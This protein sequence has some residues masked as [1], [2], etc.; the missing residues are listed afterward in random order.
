MP[1]PTTTT[2]P[3]TKGYG[4]ASRGSM[5]T[6]RPSTDEGSW[7]ESILPGLAAAATVAGGA[8]LLK[9]NPGSIG[10]VAS[11][12]NQLRQQLMLS[13][14]AL[15]KSLLGNAGAAV[16]QSFERGTT[17][18][19]SELLSAQTVR[20]AAAAW[21]R[22]ATGGA[23]QGGQAP[24]GGNVFTKAASVFAPGRAMGAMDEATQK[25][26]QRAGLSAKEAEAAALQS[27][28]EPGVAEALDSP[29]ARYV[30]PFRRQPFNQFLEG[31]KTV[32]DVGTGRMPQHPKTLA[33]YSLAGGVHGMATEEDPIPASLPLAM[34]ASGKYAL[35]YAIA[36]L[37]GRNVVGGKGMGGIPGSV[38]PVSEYGFGSAFSRPT[39]PFT[40]PAAL[41]ALEKLLGP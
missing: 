6:A 3:P 4:S 7:A 36:A 26:L 5:G 18:P 31:W 22:G 21:K 27:P 19:I 2:S 32:K 20:D 9:N 11:G 12:L 23:A 24:T 29:L 30:H 41:T 25:A 35:P 13:G 39:R 28:L 40:H 8:A 15:P 10:K 14:W 34:A 1:F 33:G 17:R 37:I 38:L 16:S